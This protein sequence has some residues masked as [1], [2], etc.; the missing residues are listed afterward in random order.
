MYKY[1]LIFL[2]TLPAWASNAP[3]RTNCS[4][5][6]DL[7]AKTACG[8]EG[9]PLQFGYRMCEKYRLAEKNQT[10]GIKEWFPKIRYCLQDYLAKNSGRAKTCR[11]LADMAYASHINCYLNTGYCALPANDVTR[12]LNITG[13]DILNPHVLAIGT[14]IS[15]KCMERGFALR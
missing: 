12:I 10:E 5:Y 1:L 6:L 13:P 4:F 8:Y 15:A 2:V 7:E 9:Y 14:E 11:Q 3:S